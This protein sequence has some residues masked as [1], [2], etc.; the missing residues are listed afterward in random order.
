MVSLQKVFVEN[1]IRAK[2]YKVKIE[3]IILVEKGKTEMFNTFPTAEAFKHEE[4]GDD[5]NNM[6]N[7][8][9]EDQHDFKRINNEIH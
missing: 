9:V 8:G 1:Q 6:G 4:I 3:Q 7:N 2:K 5:E